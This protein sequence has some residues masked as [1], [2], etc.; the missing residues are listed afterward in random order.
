MN[1]DP[2]AART[3]GK[4]PL[5]IATSLAI[6][7]GLGEHPDRPTGKNVLKNYKLAYFNIGTLY[8]NLYNAV[9]KEDVPMLLPDELAAALVM[10]L[11]QLERVIETELQG[12]LRCEFYICDYSSMEKTFPNAFLR[13]DQTANQKQY[14]LLE[15]ITLQHVHTVLNERIHRFNL[16]IKAT[17]SVKTLMLTHYP[18]DLFT[19]SIPDRALWE[20]HTG[21]VKEKHQWYTKYFNGKDLTMIP[22]R[23]D[24]LQIF[25]DNEHF[26]PMSIKYRKAIVEIAV[27]NGWSQVTTQ[28]KIDLAMNLYAEPEVRD[29]Y[30]SLRF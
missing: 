4:Y 3:L 15:K 14:A 26:R 27:N 20:S 18:I 28:A 9:L 6:E 16:R 22:F 8:R 24:L 5:S 11:D 17:S 19:P 13:T 1:I 7:G 30:R 21:A 25:G 2:T 29:L 23:E 12:K 10:E